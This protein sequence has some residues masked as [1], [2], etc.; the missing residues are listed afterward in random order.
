MSLSKSDQKIISIAYEQ[1]IQSPCKFQHG[2]IATING[3][4]IAMGYNNYRQWSK[5][6]IID[7]PCSCHAEMDVLRKSLNAV[8]YI[9]FNFFPFVFI[10]PK[11]GVQFFIC[12]YTVHYNYRSW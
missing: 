2:C 1:A 8:V 9:F 4:I 5:D 3:K 10:I 12:Y 7:D 11:I 6:G